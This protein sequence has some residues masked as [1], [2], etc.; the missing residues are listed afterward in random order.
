MQLIILN[1]CSSIKVFRKH[2]D[3]SFVF[4]HKKTFLGFITRYPGFYRTPLFLYDIHFSL[5]DFNKLNH[6]INEKKIK[7]YIENNEV[8]YL[9][10]IEFKMNNGNVF[11]KY[12]SSE[13]ELESYLRH[14]IINLADRNNIEI[15]EI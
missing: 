4:L 8:F 7:R 5:D 14:Q 13:Q 1:N 3:K 9:P 15:V 11:E 2:K 10:H 12:F 6:E